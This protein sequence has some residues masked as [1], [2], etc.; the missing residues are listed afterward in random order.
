MKKL[1]LANKL[2]ISRIIC[3]PL[4]V[5]LFLL[6]IPLGIGK[7]F[8]L[9][10]YI[11]ACV[12]DFFDGKVARKYNQV[13]DFGKFADQI[14]D[15]FLTT[16]ALICV[17]FYIT[18]AWLATL[19]IL[20][21]VLRDI[22]ISGVRM[23]AAKDGVVIA[24]DIFGK[25]KSFVLD[26]GCIVAMFY[27][28]CAFAG[29]MSNFFRVLALVGVVGGAILALISCC[30]YMTNA[31]PLIT[32]SLEGAQENNEKAPEEATEQPEKEA[33]EPKEEAEKPEKTEE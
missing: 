24:A 5:L 8:A 22:L 31:W 30:I 14:A 13:S 6:P 18:D 11:I 29:W 3:T 15:K 33:D 27:I 12:T 4:M 16:S 7:F 20:V 10:V 17:A 32:K 23:L 9:G 26:C 2:T 19:V 1:N 28:G 25:I 21:V